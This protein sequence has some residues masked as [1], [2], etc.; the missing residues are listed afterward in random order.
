MS[1]ILLSFLFIIR[2]YGQYANTHVVLEY[3]STRVEGSTMHNYH[4]V[5]SYC[6]MFYVMSDEGIKKFMLEDMKTYSIQDLTDNLRRSICTRVV[7]YSYVK[8]AD[9]YLC[10]FVQ[11]TWTIKSTTR[12]RT[13]C[14]NWFLRFSKIQAV[15]NGI[16]LE[17]LREELREHEKERTL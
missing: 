5:H 13:P 7:F 6:T 9:R 2:Q 8:R 3:S 16:H 1:K 10:L 12:S 4:E 14:S 11:S 17:I 15:Q